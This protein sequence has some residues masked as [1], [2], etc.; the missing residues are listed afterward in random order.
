MCMGA[1]QRCP[2]ARGRS[3]LE[4]GTGLERAWL[5][6]AGGGPGRL[7]GGPERPG[8]VM[9]SRPGRAVWNAEHLGHRH[10]GKAHVVMEDEHRPL[11]EREPAERR[12]QLVAVVN[13]AKTV[14]P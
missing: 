11:V 12:L 6:L 8:C 1:S 3:R 5:G 13:G 2:G 4:S 14:E 7:E 10:E 9:Q